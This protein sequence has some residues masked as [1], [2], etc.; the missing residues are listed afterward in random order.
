MITIDQLLESVDLDFEPRFVTKDMDGTIWIWNAK[1]DRFENW[2]LKPDVA[3][4][5]YGR[6]ISERLKLAEFENKH[7]TECIYEVPRKT[8]GKIERLPT[9]APFGC[10]GDWREKINE[11]VDAVNELKAKFALPTLNPDLTDEDLRKMMCDPKYWRDKDPVI[12]QKIQNGFNK[13]YGDNELK[14][15]KNE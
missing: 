7:W 9:S 14:G 12:T 13:L 2:H 15:A 11:L 4:S 5:F 6:F 10:Q 3:N 1:P 8:T